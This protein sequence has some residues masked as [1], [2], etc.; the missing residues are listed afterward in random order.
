MERYL[1]SRSEYV[2]GIFVGMDRDPLLKGI[3]VEGA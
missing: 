1:S 2:D 3:L